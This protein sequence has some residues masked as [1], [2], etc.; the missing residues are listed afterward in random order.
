MTIA[1]QKEQGMQEPAASVPST[2]FGAP[3]G[4]WTLVMLPDTQDMLDGQPEAFH[5]Q[6]EW[7]A[8]NKASHNILFLAHVGDV[9]ENNSHEQ[10]QI[11]RRAM[12]VLKGT[13]L[14]YALITGNH[15]LGEGGKTTDR[16][17]R[18]NDYFSG[19]DY[20]KSAVFFEP[21]HMENS[22]HELDTPW[23]PFLLLSLECGPSDEVVEWAGRVLAGHP[24]HRAIIVTHA[25]LNEAGMLMG[26]TA[27][28]GA[29]IVFK[30]YGAAKSGSFNDGEELWD[31]LLS[32]HANIRLVLC[33]H[34]PSA[35]GARL[36]KI[37]D[38]GN[39]VQMMLANY[40]RPA[41]ADGGGGYLRLLRFLPDGKTVEVK[42]YSPWYDDWLGVPHEFMMELS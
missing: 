37:G 11:A 13:Q 35:E 17:T 24:G 41:R 18:L 16:M 15:D 9:T 6:I 7:V 25:C 31:K 32:K 28:D 20:G 5:R 36:T 22:F 39:P 23:G 3:G 26:A 8:L 12:D 14:P 4:T 21:G 10:W 1:V 29:S 27:G 19:E 2:P 34:D 42:T 33:G 40:Q 38:A 30:N